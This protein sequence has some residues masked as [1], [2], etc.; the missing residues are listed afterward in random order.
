MIVNNL[1]SF[2]PIRAPHQADAPLSVDSNG[3]LAQ[4]IA[5]QRLETISWGHAQIV[6][7]Q[8]PVEIAEFPTG[9]VLYVARQFPTTLSVKDPLGFWAPEGLNHDSIIISLIPFSVNR[10]TARSDSGHR[11][12]AYLVEDIDAHAKRLGI[13]RSSFLAEAAR[14]ALRGA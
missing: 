14:T 4:T 1:D 9:R 10:K 7:G 3:I 12:Y 11:R 8:R 13:T 2:R 5:T 6:T